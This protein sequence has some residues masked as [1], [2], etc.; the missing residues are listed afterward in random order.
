MMLKM[1]STLVLSIVSF[2]FFI[3]L[4]LPIGFVWRK[5]MDPMT[6]SKKPHQDSYKFLSYKD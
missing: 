5:T 4:I 2:M 6:L 1:L 3:L